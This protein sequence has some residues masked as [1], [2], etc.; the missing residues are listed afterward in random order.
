MRSEPA[1]RILHV[2]RVPASASLGML[3]FQGEW[4][5]SPVPGALEL[6][7][8]KVRLEPLPAPPGADAATGFRAA[9]AL[10]IERL[11]DL[12]STWSLESEAGGRVEVEWPDSEQAA[13]VTRPDA[14]A[15]VA[16]AATEA[17]ME[18]REQGEELVRQRDAEIARLRADLDE[19][20]SILANADEKVDAAQQASTAMSRR[21]RQAEQDAQEARQAAR[22]LEAAVDEPRAALSSERARVAELEAALA[23]ERERRLELEGEIGPAVDRLA[24]ALEAARAAEGA[25]AALQA[26]SAEHSQ[27]NS[28]IELE[29]TEQRQLAAKLEHALADALAAQR[30]G[31]ADQGA[32]AT[33]QAELAAERQGHEGAQQALAAQVERT[34]ELQRD[35]RSRDGREAA[36]RAAIATLEDELFAARAE[37]DEQRARGAAT[38]TEVDAVARAEADAAHAQLDAARSE[39][40]Q[41]LAAHEALAA[42]L[43]EEARAREAHDAELHQTIAALESELES[44]GAAPEDGDS[45]TADA[46]LVNERERANGLERLLADRDR[47][48]RDLHQRVAELEAELRA[49]SA[50]ATGMESEL[51]NLDDGIRATRSATIVSVDGANDPVGPR[52]TPPARLNGGDRDEFAARLERA[53]QAIQ[54]VEDPGA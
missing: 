41:M 29:L 3:R 33:L 11:D 38:A 4:T 32:L 28:R 53:N 47:G 51:A 45:A 42:Q 39:L 7:A 49:A 22:A 15:S 35:L 24:A 18:V 17:L 48:E 44:A 8:G 25:A 37:V 6:V 20:L 34:E 31:A 9:F 52:R 30:A 2:E 43:E 21:L 5:G 46:A 54:Q 23:G 12:G 10:P 36:Q 16:Q 26:A 27:R 50:R 19:A 13:P 1:L 40:E 14:A